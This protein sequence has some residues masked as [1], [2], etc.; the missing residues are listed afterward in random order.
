VDIQVEV[1][2]FKCLCEVGNGAG[3]EI[4]CTLSRPLTVIS[5]RWWACQWCKHNSWG[6]TGLLCP[7]TSVIPLHTILPF[8]LTWDAVTVWTRLRVL[9]LS[10]H[11]PHLCGVFH[12]PKELPGTQRPPSPYLILGR[13]FCHFAKINCFLPKPSPPSCSCHCGS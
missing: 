11:G 3:M 9:I 10:H 7:E 12:L 2:Q 8:C 1:A 5:V 13:V 6:S 4:V